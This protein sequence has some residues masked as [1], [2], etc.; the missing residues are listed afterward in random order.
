MTNF[1]SQPSIEAIQTLLV[2]GNVLSYNMNP[3]VS[4]VLLGMPDTVGTDRF[5]CFAFGLTIPRYDIA[6]GLGA[7]IARRVKS[8]YAI[9]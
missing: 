9:R 2:I 5:C 7:W 3:G 1:L 4:Y 6:N 8:I